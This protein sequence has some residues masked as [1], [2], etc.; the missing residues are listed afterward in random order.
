MGVNEEAAI[1][2][3]GA[4]PPRGPAVRRQTGEYLLAFRPQ[5]ADC[6]SSLPIQAGIPFQSAIENDAD[7]VVGPSVP[8]SGDLD[9]GKHEC[10]H[11]L[12]AQLGGDANSGGLANGLQCL[13][14][15][16]HSAAGPC[17]SSPL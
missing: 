17:C 5:A 6:P 15:L 9:I 2:T 11:G 1:G 16:P 8:L 13:P 4:P 12:V 3:H 7:R 10:R 14:A